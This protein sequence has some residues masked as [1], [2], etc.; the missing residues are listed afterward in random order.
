MAAEFYAEMPQASG[1]A[2]EMLLAE[3]VKRTKEA[4]ARYFELWTPAHAQ[5]GGMLVAHGFAGFRRQLRS[6]ERPME[7]APRWNDF[8]F[9]SLRNLGSGNT[10]IQGL[11]TFLHEAYLGSAD[12]D[13]YEEYKDCQQCQRYLSR[14][15]A[16]PYCDF[17]N[18]W[19]AWSP[20]ANTAAGLALCYIWP[21]ARGLYLEQL[22]VHPT[23]RGKGLA[24][25]LLSR[26]SSALLDGSLT[27]ILS[28]VSANN[29]AGIRLYESVGAHVLDY[30]TAYVKKS[31]TSETYP[32]QQDTTSSTRCRDEITAAA[33]VG[34]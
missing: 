29:S 30:E 9:I 23:F 5:I 3:F 2:V 19:I 11:A 28:T 7:S 24:K 27:R 20:Q 34:P 17:Q 18:S 25:V 10:G 33:T 4:A 14:V 8:R 12:G 16:S 15:L 1:E 13:F 31:P 32:N 6:L 21:G 26:V 22:A